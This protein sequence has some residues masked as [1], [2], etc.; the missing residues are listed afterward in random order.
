MV[1]HR[2]CCSSDTKAPS[3]E[4]QDGEFHGPLEQRECRDVIFLIIFIAFIFG[5][6]GITYI[7]V[8]QGNPYRLVYGVDSYGNVCNQ[9]NDKID[10]VFYSGQ[11][12]TDKPKVFF[13][14]PTYFTSMLPNS[15]FP[16]FSED[17]TEIICIEKCPPNETEVIDFF[18]NEGVNLC[19]YNVTPYVD[20][21]KQCPATPVQKHESVFNRCIPEYIVKYAKDIASSFASVLSNSYMGSNAPQKIVSDLKNTWIEIGYLSAISVGVAFIVVLLMR[22]LAAVIV[23]T[24]VIGVMLFSMG[25][26]TYCW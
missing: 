4:D 6:F 13:F 17:D 11:D 15:P 9:K 3:D 21:I 8:K 24:L 2:C 22:F 14:D 20:N 26:S 18:M 25:A 19:H 12:N 7:S 10:G 5:I 23:W 1:C 16:S